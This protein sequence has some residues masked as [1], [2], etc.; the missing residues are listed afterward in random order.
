LEVQQGLPL[1]DLFGVGAAVEVPLV[2]MEVMVEQSMQTIPQQMGEMHQ[3]D[4][5]TLLL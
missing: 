5:F 4:F 2:E 1:V 3:P